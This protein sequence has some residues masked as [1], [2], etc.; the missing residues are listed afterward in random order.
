[1]TLREFTSGKAIAARSAISFDMNFLWA[2]FFLIALLLLPSTALAQDPLSASLCTVIKWFTGGLGR[3]IATLGI[4]VVAIGAL[5][6]KVSWQLGVTVVVGISVMFGAAQLVDLLLMGTTN[7][8]AV[9]LCDQYTETPGAGAIERV[10]CNLADMANSATGKAFGTFAIITLGV[11]ALMGKLSPAMSLLSAVGIAMLFGA[12]ELATSLANAVG[13]TEFGEVCS[14]PETD[15][16]L[17]DEDAVTADADFN[18]ALDAGS[19]LTSDRVGAVGQG[20]LT[21]EGLYERVR[22]GESFSI[23]SALKPIDEG[24]REVQSRDVPSAVDAGTTL[25]GERVGARGQGQLNGPSGVKALDD[26]DAITTPDLYA[27]VG[28]GGALNG[29]RVGA[30]PNRE[31]QEL[32]PI[33]GE[34]RPESNNSGGN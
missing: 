12:N 8:T 6:G 24:S 3:A 34:L 26:G 5:M 30:N 22:E 20:G 31:V 15:D 11:T 32:T 21:T 16:P 19:E 4:L 13:Q 29:E 18:G 10:L 33:Q 14:P 17:F 1:M 7:V 23:P 9:G 25:T 28:N 2:V 27:P